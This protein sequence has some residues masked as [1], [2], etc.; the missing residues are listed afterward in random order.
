MLL[1]MYLILII[2][3]ISIYF[4]T[5][6]TSERLAGGG[7]DQYLIHYVHC[8]SFFAWGYFKLLVITLSRLNITLQVTLCTETNNQIGKVRVLLQHMC[9]Q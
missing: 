7:F 9:A 8:L 4:M 3:H 5:F 1:C 2:T 6:S